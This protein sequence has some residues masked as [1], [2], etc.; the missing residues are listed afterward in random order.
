MILEAVKDR[1]KDRG[2]GWVL[3]RCP[4][5]N[6]WDYALQGSDT[7]LVKPGVYNCDECGLPFE[8]KGEP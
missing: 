5:C 8:I 7:L 3:Y 1:S 6:C 2:D 4:H